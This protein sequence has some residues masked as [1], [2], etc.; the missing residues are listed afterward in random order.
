MV[1]RKDR[2][3]ERQREE[4]IRESNRRSIHDSSEK[5]SVNPEKMQRPQEQSKPTDR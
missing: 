4:T 2:G 5:S 1:D 3:S